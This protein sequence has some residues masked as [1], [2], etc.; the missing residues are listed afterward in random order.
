MRFRRGGEYVFGH[1]GSVNGFKAE[2]FFHPES[3]TCVAIVANDFNGQTR[4]LSI[5]IW[6]LLLAE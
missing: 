4:P 2:L 5:A 6:D 1:T 3:E